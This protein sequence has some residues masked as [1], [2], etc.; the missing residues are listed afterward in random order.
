LIRSDLILSFVS[1][2]I[3]NKPHKVMI[4]NSLSILKMFIAGWFLLPVLVLADQRFVSD[5]FEV[6]LRTGPSGSHAI[7]RV[8]KSGTELKELERDTENGYSRVQTTAGTEGWVLS[9]Y[10]ISEPVARVQIENLAKQVTNTEP[11]DK[12]TQGQLNFV[13]NEFENAHK[14]ISELEREK[15][16][17]EK[18]LNDIQNKAANVLTIDAENKQLHQQY[19]EA[20]AQLK[21][22]QEQYSEVSNDNEREWFITGAMVLF[23]GLLL[24]LVIPKISWRKKRSP[25]GD[26]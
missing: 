6:L 24:G 23:G 13:K 14:R 8:L 21:T 4:R 18:R 19:N 20:K 22:L 7:V 25:Y 15:Q 1:N 26:F 11:K 2:H 16:E 3:V 9:R 17:L 5:Q 10:L 12:T